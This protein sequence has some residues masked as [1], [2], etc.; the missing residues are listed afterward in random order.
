MKAAVCHAQKTPV[1]VE[2]VELEAPR[3]GE[4]MVELVGAG[5]CHS[6]YHFVD[7]HIS[8][9]RFPFVLGHEG[10]GIVKEAGPGVANVAPGD[11]IIFSLDAMCGHCRNCTQG[12]PTLCETYGRSF[13]MPDGTT[14]FSKAEVPYYSMVATFSE[15]TVVPA[16]KVVKIRDDVPLEKVCLV[17]CA[18]ITGVGSVINRAQV[19]AGSTVAVY[20]CGGVGLNVIQGAVL[21]SASKIIPSTGWPSSWRRRRRWAPPTSSTLRPRTPSRGSTRSPAAG[22]T[23]PS[24]SLGTPSWSAWP[25]NRSG[26][27]AR[28]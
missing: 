12:R 16:D 20:G 11:H 2:E 3:A 1:I 19:E 8:L 14:R 9:D 24:R 7:G 15:R 28:P 27:E 26:P 4:V 23:M 25:S 10:A 5:V 17:G 6:D 18:V 13:T 22:P 21:A